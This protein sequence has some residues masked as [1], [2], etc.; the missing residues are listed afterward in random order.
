LIIWKG[1]GEGKYPYAIL[2][3]RK[4]WDDLTVFFQ[5]SL[6]IRSIIYT[7]NL[8]ENLNGKSGSTLSPNYHFPRRGCPKKDG[9]P[10]VGGD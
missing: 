9:L 8:I 7:T 4:H 3:W 5:F 2:S 6:E 10:L 1:N